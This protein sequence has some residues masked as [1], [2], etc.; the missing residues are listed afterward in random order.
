MAAVENVGI[1]GP[2]TPAYTR[3]VII[4][5]AGR[6]DVTCGNSIRRYSGRQCGDTQSPCPPGCIYTESKC[7]QSGDRQFTEPVPARPA[8]TQ[9]MAVD[10]PR[11]PDAAKEMGGQ[12]YGKDLEEI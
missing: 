3:E 4:D 6:V 9:V 2:H 7:R 5:N 11:M 1:L 12:K 10:S 8:Y